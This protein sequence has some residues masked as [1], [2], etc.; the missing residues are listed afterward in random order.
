MSKTM[1]ERTA[2]ALAMDR[3]VNM[4]SINAGLLM[5][6]DQHQDL[7]IQKNPYLR[8]ASEMYEDGVLV[9][10]DLGILVDTHI[11][12]YE[13]ISSY[14]RYLCFN[15]VINTQHDAVQLAHKTTT[16]LSCDPGKEFIQ[17]R[18]S[19]KKL[20][21]LMVNFNSSEAVLAPCFAASNEDRRC[22][23]M[24]ALEVGGVVV[25]VVASEEA[26]KKQPSLPPE[27]K[28]LSWSSVKKLRLVKKWDAHVYH[29]HVRP[30]QEKLHN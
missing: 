15:H 18:I 13:D 29:N 16:P 20:N 14:G 26:E 12:V 2:W 4:V 23:K 30:L 27:K 22:I 17:Q 7:C 3:E 28:S 19:N 1:A 10:V 8:G 9:T 25:V 21:E 6:S 5:S 11:C 24:E